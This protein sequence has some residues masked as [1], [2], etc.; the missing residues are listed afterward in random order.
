MQIPFENMSSFLSRCD[1]LTHVFFSAGAHHHVEQIYGTGTVDPFDLDQLPLVRA[2]DWVP[3]AVQTTSRTV[4][5]FVPSWI[6]G[7]RPWLEGA[8]EESV[9]VEQ[10]RR[11][12]FEFPRE[13]SGLD[14]NGQ[15]WLL[16]IFTNKT[17]FKICFV[18]ISVRT[19]NKVVAHGQVLFYRGGFLT[20]CLINHQSA[21]P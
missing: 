21:A 13:S 14:L 6:S 9:F 5:T 10:K 1:L 11:G 19:W 2:S 8:G 12:D 4:R 7:K 3:S 17:S 16:S 18:M 15:R 20:Q